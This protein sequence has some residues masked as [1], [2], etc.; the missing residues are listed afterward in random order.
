MINAAMTLKDGQKAF[1]IGLEADNVV[2]L[3]AGQPIRFSIGKY[4]PELDGWDIVIIGPDESLE[5]GRRIASGELQVGRI[6]N[7]RGGH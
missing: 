4:V 7:E 6:F 2:R 3:L 5:F 1:L